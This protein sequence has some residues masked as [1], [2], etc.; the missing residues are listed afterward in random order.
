MGKQQ[1]WGSKFE[2]DNC[3][4]KEK[5]LLNVGLGGDPVVISTVILCGDEGNLKEVWYSN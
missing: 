5:K 4:R 2:R 3:A 1:S